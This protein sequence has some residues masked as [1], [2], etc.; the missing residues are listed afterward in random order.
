MRRVTIIFWI[1]VY[2]SWIALPVTSQGLFE[3]S[4]PGNQE[5]LVSNKLSMGGFIRSVGYTAH[6]PENDKYYLQSAYGQVGLLLDAKAGEWA[7]AKADVRFRYG[8][9]FK[10]PLSQAEIREAYIDVWKG[11]LSLRFGKMITPWG[12][13]TVFNP[14]D[15]L[16][17]QDPTIRSPEEDDMK[18]GFWGIRGGLDLG[19]SMKLTASWKPVYQPSVLLIDPVPMPAY[20]KF[21]E[22]DY[23][24]LELDEGSYGIRYDLFTSALDASLYWFDGY[25]QW[26]GIAYDSFLPDMATM[27]PLELNLYEKAY[28]IR[29]AGADISFPTGSWILRAEGAWQHS[30]ENFAGHEYIPF[31][32]LTYT[33]EMERTGT[34][35]SLL[36]GYHGKYIL[37]FTEPMAEPSLSASQ[38]Q[39]YQMAQQ[40][41]ISEAGDMDQLIR[42][43]IGAF[44]RLYNYQ[45]EE[46]YHTLFLVGKLLLWYNQ[47]EV[48]LPL[49]HNLTTSEWIIRPGIAW[50]PA[51]G[52]KISAGY[53]GMYG[54]DNS[55]YD[56]VG[57][58]LNSGYMSVRVTF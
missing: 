24:G 34:Y 33:A 53:Q 31:T 10:Q 9:E 28:K 55:L 48:T 16:T 7:A 1:I 52:L 23:P 38:D 30:R 37:E 13:G 39:F 47:V 36:G 44:N 12:K 22:P 8:S 56:M 51:D 26:T 41:L 18:L 6:S 2:S 35:L 42:E 57:P 17:P 49:I 40:G 54:P 27:E 15:K 46:F 19:R 29:M 3:S 43:Q 58:V 50:M 11:P 45:I 21:L 5:K 4:L 14:V 25:S 32:E 20:V